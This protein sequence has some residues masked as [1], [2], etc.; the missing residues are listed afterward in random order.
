M[1]RLSV[2]GGGVSRRRFLASSGAAMGVAGLAACSIA[3][4]QKPGAAN[5]SGGTNTGAIG[6]KEAPDLAQRAKSGD[7][8][9]LT[10][11]LPAQP[12]VVTPT[13]SS[14]NYGGTWHST[15]LGPSDSTWL[16]RAV[17]YEYLLRWKPDTVTHSID[18]IVPNVAESYESNAEKTQYTFHLRDGMKWSDGQPFNAGDIVF[19]VNNVYLNDK[20]FPATPLGLLSDG[21]PPKVKKVDDK[22]VTFTFV[23]P[24]PLF[25]LWLASKNSGINQIAGYPMHY[26]KQF[27][28][29]FNPDVE[30]LSKKAKVSDWIELFSSKTDYWA[31]H[32]LPRLHA[33]LP[34]ADLGSGTNFTLNRNP[35]YWKTDPSGRQLPYIDTMDIALITDIQTMTLRAEHGDIDMYDRLINTLEAKPVLAS[36]RD[37]GQYGFFD[38]NTSTMNTCIISLNLTHKDP[39]KR[40]MFQ[41]RDFRIGLSYALNRPEIIKTVYKGLGTP[42]Q[43]AP[44]KGSKYYDEALGTQY[45]KFSLDLANQYL[46]KAGFRRQGN[47]PR[48]G[49]DGKPIAF[50]VEIATR[51]YGFDWPST[52]E[53]VTGYWKA[54]GIQLHVRSEDVDLLY[55]RKDANQHDA[56]VWL[57]DVGGLDPHLD[58]RYLFPN[59]HESNYAELWQVWYTSLGKEGERPPAAPRKQMSLYTQFT[60][61]VDEQKQAR[62]MG[63]IMSISRQQFYTIGVAQPTGR[64]GIEKNNFKSVL[65]GYLE[66]S[67]YPNPGPTNPEQYYI[68]SH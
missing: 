48:I 63:Q 27:H 14:G 40:K 47:G 3:P 13:Q 53:L 28:K 57:G 68:T 38:L 1:S 56:V 31:N 6:A 4:K 60:Q 46:D 64:Y 36:S 25:P 11:R 45:T 37:T 34:T 50:T 30:K 24:S 49:P 35:Y 52:M 61:E 10:E 42:W 20:L 62:L 18:D 59:N 32:E 39:V 65:N 9:Q 12:L 21:Q 15:M 22:T 29:D 19:A 7:L 44:R 26:L 43:A 2:S 41:N 58:P 33:W 17:G 8:P 55:T 54:V 23:K 51:D 16:D 66:G 67:N 5:N